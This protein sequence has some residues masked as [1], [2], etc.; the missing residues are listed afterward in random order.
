MK[1]LILFAVAALC[2]ANLF[3]QVYVGGTFGVNTIGT[4]TNTVVMEGVS[5]ETKTPGNFK[6][7]VNPN[8]G[9]IL[10]DKLSVGVQLPVTIGPN[11]KNDDAKTSSSSLELGIAPY[12][13]YTFMT[14]GKFGLAA[15]ASVGY[16][17]LKETDSNVV[18]EKT[19]KDFSE[20]GT[21]SISAAPVLTYAL[22]KNIVLEAYFDLFELRFASTTQKD[23]SSENSNY[24]KTSNSTFAF[25]ATSEDALP[26]G[27]LFIGFTYRF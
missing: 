16:S 17:F 27:W 5:T 20:T 21:F 1:K 9:Y 19:V 10:N 7:T 25:S 11:S 15:E 18:G 6:V 14:F 12:A 4:K 13:R 23:Y 8:I 24:S 26:L 3:A 2:S 22:N